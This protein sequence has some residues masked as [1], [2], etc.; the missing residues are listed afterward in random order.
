MTDLYVV[1]SQGEVTAVIPDMAWTL[2]GS[3]IFEEEGED[4]LFRYSS[5]QVSEF[6][7]NAYAKK[8]LLQGIVAPYTILQAEDRNALMP[9]Y[10]LYIGD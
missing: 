8:D 1:D 2:D 5:S 7:I 10:E 4:Y 3:Y 9:A 6:F